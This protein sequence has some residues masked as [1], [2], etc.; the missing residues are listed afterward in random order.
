[1]VYI[2]KDLFTIVMDGRV[3]V[4]MMGNIYEWDGRGSRWVW[5]C[6]L[7]VCVSVVSGDCGFAGQT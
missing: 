2:P 6:L 3:K 1:M 4:S 7:G 5:R